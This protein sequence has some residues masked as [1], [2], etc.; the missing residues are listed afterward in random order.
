MTMNSYNESITLKFAGDLNALGAAGTLDLGTPPD[1][2][3][4]VDGYVD[5]A[6][7]TTNNELSLGDGTTANLFLDDVTFAAATIDG[8]DILV[9][10][11]GTKFDGTATVTAKNTGSAAVPSSATAITVVLRG[12]MEHEA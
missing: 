4:L 7:G 12:Y 3:V 2:F 6:Q 1:N 10:S 5:C 11:R 9:T 8:L